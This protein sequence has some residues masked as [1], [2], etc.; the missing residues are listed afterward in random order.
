MNYPQAIVIA[1]ALLASAIAFSG[2]SV[3]QSNPTTYSA[4]SAASGPTSPVTSS[5]WVVIGGVVYLC[6]GAPNVMPACKT[7]TL[8]R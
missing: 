3:A 2:R 4:V 6:D 1:A 7:V 8:P 5:A